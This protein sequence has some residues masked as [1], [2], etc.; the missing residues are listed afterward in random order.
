M[1]GLCEEYRG[2][3]LGKKHFPLLN[4]CTVYGLIVYRYKFVI[5]KMIALF[6][7]RE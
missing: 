1:W 2:I 4:I 5:E 3:I 6:A 7:G